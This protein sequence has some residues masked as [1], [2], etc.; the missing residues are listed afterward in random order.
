MGRV[1]DANIFY[2][3]MVRIAGVGEGGWAGSSIT[4]QLNNS[5][6]FCVL[7]IEEMRYCKPQLKCNM[8]G[9]LLLFMT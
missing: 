2:W 6:R 7:K 1:I 5:I 9:R 3:E 4:K 8:A